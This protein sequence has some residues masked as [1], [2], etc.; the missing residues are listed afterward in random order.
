MWC[1]LPDDVVALIARIIDVTALPPLNTLCHA[2]Y[3]LTSQRLHAMRALTRS[4]FFMSKD[5]IFDKE[6]FFWKSVWY[7]GKEEM[8]TFTRAKL[9]GAMPGLRLLYLHGCG[10]T[11]ACMF[12]L[13]CRLPDAFSQLVE[14]NLNNNC[15]GDKGMTI[16]G[17]ALSG[18]SLAQLE[19]L[20][21]S[22]NVLYD[23]GLCSFAAECH[24]NSL[25]SLTRLS[26]GSNFF[27]NRGLQALSAAA[28]SKGC[29][30]KLNTIWLNHNFVRSA[31]MNS[32]LN[33]NF[34]HMEKLFLFSNYIDGIIE[35][36]G[37]ANIVCL[38]LGDNPL[39]DS[40]VLRLFHMGTKFKR[41]QTL[42]L[43]ECTISDDCMSSVAQLMNDS[44]VLPALQAL[45][46]D[47]PVRPE[48]SRMCALR[49]IV[50]G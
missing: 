37:I 39:T 7:I 6:L 42:E 14:L 32:L 31:G 44:R 3:A 33:G 12:H 17:R 22:K 47:I 27:G 11:D 48:I 23:D 25:P 10:I 35:S 18:Q 36:V 8:D 28:R 40:D 13:T 20:Y 34:P 41:L 4:P 45:V 43:A 30:Q 46:L 21:L 50:C 29:F 49:G 9:A 5:D 16:L 2:T 38:V 1:H 15:I 26:L 19:E 24:A